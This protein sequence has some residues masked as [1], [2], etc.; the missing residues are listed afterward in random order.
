MGFSLTK[1]GGMPTLTGMDHITGVALFQILGLSVAANLILAGFVW[2]AWHI[3]KAERETDDPFNT[4]AWAWV[5][6]IG[7]FLLIGLGGYLGIIAE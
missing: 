6:V 4:T 7:P 2:G 5:A 3:N 1:E